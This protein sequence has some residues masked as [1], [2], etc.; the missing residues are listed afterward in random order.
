MLTPNARLSDLHPL[1]AQKIHGIA[2][3][4][5]KL[6][7]SGQDYGI[8]LIAEG[9]HPELPSGVRPAQTLATYLQT[10]SCTPG[11]VFSNGEVRM[12]ES[13]ALLALP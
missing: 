4:L 3:R 10:N 12:R 7:T 1:T 6:L 13:L 5:K 8:V 2:E 11:S 9:V